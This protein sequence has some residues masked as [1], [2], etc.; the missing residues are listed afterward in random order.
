MAVSLELL[1]PK[2]GKGKIQWMICSVLMS[3]L[4]NLLGLNV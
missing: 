4:K 3:S 2:I 1:E